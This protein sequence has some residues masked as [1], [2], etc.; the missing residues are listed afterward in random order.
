LLPR[1]SPYALALLAHALSLPGI[2]VFDDYSLLAQ[3]VELPQ[4]LRLEQTRPLTYLTFWLNQSLGG[5]HLL[6]LAAHLLS[7]AL[8]DRIARRL[9]PPDIA[10]VPALLFAVHPLLSEPVQYLFA[11]SSLLA[12][13]FCLA[14]LDAWTRQKHWTAVAWF[15]PALLAK[16][17]CVAF[18]F[19]L[20]LLRPAWPPLAAMLALSAAAG[21]RVLYATK[22]VAGAGSGFDAGITPG[23]YFLAQGLVLWGYLLRLILPH[24]L[25]LDPPAPTPNLEASVLGWVALLVLT[26]VALWRGHPAGRWFAFGL[27]LLLP[28]SS[29]LPAADLVAWRRLYLPMTAFCLAAAYLLPRRALLP[30]LA[31]FTVLSAARALAWRDEA[32]LWRE[33]AAA[34]PAKLRPRLQ[35]ARLAPPAEAL[36]LLAEAEQIAPGDPQIASLRG[37]AYLQQGDAP[38]ALAEFGKA[39]A[40]RPGDPKAILNRGAA[41]EAL[42]QLDAAKADYRR[43]LERDPCQAQ[44]RQNLQR[45]GEPLP[46]CAPTN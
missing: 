33:A 19:A 11:R 27:I 40:Q 35:L 13:L 38:R 10:P 41:L 30:V 17:E 1:W 4:L 25:T 7:I 14:A 29:I 6:N 42:G 43:A 34:A 18:P 22:V 45:L 31:I 36:A 20:I 2:F 3:P 24:G 46:P 5:W 8:L 16:E 15:L 9:L 39:L 44:A 23:Q 12:T 21:L 26:G 28:S 32:G 37:R